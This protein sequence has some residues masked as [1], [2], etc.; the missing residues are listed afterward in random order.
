MVAIKEEKPF[1][2]SKRLAPIREQKLIPS[3]EIH[4]LANGELLLRLEIIRKEVEDEKAHESNTQKDSKASVKIQVLKK[5]SI[6]DK[7][8]EEKLVMTE[9]GTVAERVVE[10]NMNDGELKKFEADWIELWKP[11]L[12]E[13]P[14]V[15]PAL[16]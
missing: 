9:C 12:K 2:S 1:P 10:T 7:T 8:H 16:E 3:S 6:G 15:K 11:C 4:E 5:R 14:V 13:G